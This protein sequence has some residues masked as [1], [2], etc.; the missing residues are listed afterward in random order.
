MLRA[1]KRLLKPTGV[2]AYFT[3]VVA[4]NLSKS[5][6]RR[7]VRLGPRAVASNRPV[8]ELMEAAHFDH[9]K[10]VDVTQDFLRTARAWAV[11][12]EEHKDELPDILRR[13]WE[14]RQRDRKGIILGIEEGLLLRLLVTGVA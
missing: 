1:C 13:E 3:I 6:H 12:F 4:P 2:T 10:V 14:E 9:V 11:E 7:A 5:Q 8:D